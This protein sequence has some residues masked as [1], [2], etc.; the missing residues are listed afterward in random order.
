MT[1]KRLTFLQLMPVFMFSA[2]LA[3]AADAARGAALVRSENCL[4]CH[5]V[6]GEGGSTAPEL[7]S[8][9]VPVYS[10]AALAATL[11][12]HSPAMWNE[13]SSRVVTRPTPTDA[14]WED[15]FAYLYSLRFVDRPGDPKRGADV[16]RN[17]NCAFCHSLSQNPKSIGPAVSFWKPATDSVVLLS[18]MWNHAANMRREFVE[19]RKQWKRLSGRDFMDLT[20]YIRG[21]QQ[22]GGSKAQTEFTLPDSSR[23]KQLFDKSCVSCHTGAQALEV[24]LKNKTWM[25]I[26]AGMWNHVPLLQTV[27]SV[28]TEDMRRILAYVWEL[29]YNGPEGNV[30][31]GQQLFFD[32]RC[33]TCHQG[34][35]VPGKNFTEYSMVALGWG[36]GRQMHTAM[37]ERGIRWPTFNPGEI[38][39][40]VAYLNSLPAKK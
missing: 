30:M 22:V 5:R 15:V 10:P 8:G 35:P 16:F 14:E 18:Q 19:S 26:G 21:V 6:R 25:D 33:V 39:D 4:E 12:N 32:R 9:I 23:G 31:R 36:P 7:A 37:Q 34:S 20:A 28:T 13:M 40:V 11:W 29:Q 1:R 24:K 38:R 2:G 27:P 17:R 3:Q